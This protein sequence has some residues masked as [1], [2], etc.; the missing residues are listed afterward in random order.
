MPR[1][2]MG[3]T[4]LIEV[5]FYYR[6]VHVLCVSN[7]RD[8]YYLSHKAGW[9]MAGWNKAAETAS[10]NRADWNVSGGNY[11]DWNSAEWSKVDS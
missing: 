5:T 2:W 6:V 1:R 7:Q 4:S 9:N 3:S 11:A 10:F 8:T